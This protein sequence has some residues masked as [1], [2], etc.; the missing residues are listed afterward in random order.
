M[1]C[2]LYRAV[3]QWEYE[4]ILAQGNRFRPKPDGGSLEVKQFAISEQC[5]NYYGKEIVQRWDNV[6]YILIR[7][8][9][10]VPEFCKDVMPLDD[11]FAVSIQYNSLNEFNNAIV[12]FSV[13][14]KLN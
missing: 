2:I 6:D 14:E 13:I 4:D 12:E 7:V 10:N 11:C 8:E 9:L 3:T 1:P 5:G